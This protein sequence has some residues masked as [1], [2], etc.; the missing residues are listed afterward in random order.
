MSTA[1]DGKTA[2]RRHWQPPLEMLR[3]WWIR[4]GDAD[5]TP[6]VILTTQELEIRV[7]GFRKEDRRACGWFWIEQCGQMPR[8]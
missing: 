2:K 6:A 8:F 3:K 5:Q 1:K 4:K 7:S